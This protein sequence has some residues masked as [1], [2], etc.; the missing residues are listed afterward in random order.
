VC[1]VFC[2][3]CWW[4][5]RYFSELCAIPVALSRNVCAGYLNFQNIEVM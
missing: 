2:K 3:R 1:N 5:E 4:W